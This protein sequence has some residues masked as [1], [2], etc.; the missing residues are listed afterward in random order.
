[1]KNKYCD[2]K[3]LRN[4]A[5][6]ESCFVDKL[7]AD[8]GYPNSDI[9]FKTSIQEHAVGKGSKKILYKPDYML[10]TDGI[11]SVVV[12]A[13]SPEE[14]ITQWEFQCSAYCLELNK[15][16]DYNPVQHYVLANGFKLN[17]YK[18]DT[19]AP[20]LS[21]SFQDFVNGNLNLKLLKDVIGRKATKKHALQAKEDIDSSAFPFEPIGLKELTDKF[22]KLHKY[23]W[24][25]EK[26]GPSAAFQELMKI[27][28]V[29]IQ[30]D[31]QL[32]EALGPN[33]KP[34]NVNLP[35]FHLDR[36]L[37]PAQ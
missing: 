22:Q 3:D 17:L 36:P 37:F 13:K 25:T 10:K 2:S 19:R 34:K 30:K 1:M 5:S 31:R 14:D 16:F 26:K 33:P 11:P 8:L 4:E 24:R 32:Y 9:D 15:L 35:H 18:W 20:L 7:L 27:V 12:D 21:C 28:F 29:K 6:V 23:I